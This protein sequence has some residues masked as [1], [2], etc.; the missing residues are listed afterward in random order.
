MRFRTRQSVKWGL[1]S[2]LAAAAATAVHC[3]GDDTTTG[4]GGGGGSAA[5]GTAGTTAGASG[6]A[7]GQGGTGGGTAGAGGTAGSAGSATGGGGSTEAGV[8]TGAAGSANE[9]GTGDAADGAAKTYPGLEKINHIVVVYMENWSFDSLYGE[10]AGAEGLTEAKAWAQQYP[11]LDK[12]GTPYTTLPQVEFALGANYAVPD[13]GGWDAGRFFDKNDAAFIDAGPNPGP[14]GGLLAFPNAPFPLEPYLDLNSVT[15]TDLTHRYYHERMQIN[16]GKMNNW[17]SISNNAAGPQGM[18]MGYFHTEGLP[19]AAEA[20]KY[21][22]CDHF[23]HAAFG[24]S[25]L[26]HIWLIA[27][28]TPSFIGAPSSI[29][30]TIDPATQ[31]LARD[32]VTGFPVKD[33]QVTND[34]F[35]VNTSFS[36][37]TPHPNNIADPKTLVPN[38]TLPTI[39]DRLSD[40]SI[41]WAWYSGGWND[42]LAAAQIS[43][44]A[45]AAAGNASDAGVATTQ[46]AFQYHHQPFVYFDKYKDGTQ[47]KADHLKD[48]ADMMAAITAGT[49]PSVSFFKPVGIENEHPNYANMINGENHIVALINAVRSSMLWKDTAIIITYDEHGGWWDHV[50]PP[51]VDR[52]GPGARVPAIVISPYAKHGYVD[53][54]VYDTTS[55]LGLIEHRWSLAPLS[56]R[57]ANSGDLTKAFDFTQTDGG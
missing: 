57:D 46:R 7:A 50:A 44:D 54:T 42:A 10:F 14:D 17:V 31:N 39:G 36:V 24:G 18:V 35:V 32:S 43:N 26:N 29:V 2:L 20:H 55:I 1:L 33:G 16:D 48:E 11:Q 27:A 13:D 19:L 49:L 22:L 45:G 30:A 38:Q 37:N 52:W 47:A 8:E 56:A 15:K 53:K 41:T 6:S 25:F 21:T 9:A 51:K 23:F 3:G 12:N 5:G 40:K 28:A 34:G 4:A